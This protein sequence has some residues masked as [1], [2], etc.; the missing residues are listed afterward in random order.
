MRF[1]PGLTWGAD[2]NLRTTYMM[3]YLLNVQRSLGAN[4]TLELGYTGNQA[5]KVAYL[6]NANAPGGGQPDSRPLFCPR[7]LPQ[8]DRR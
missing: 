2:Y 1:A 7:G 4:S 6:V 8:R 3:Q 5:R